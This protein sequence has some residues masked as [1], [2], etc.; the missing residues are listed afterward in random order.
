MCTLQKSP[1]LRKGKYAQPKGKAEVP[2]DLG[3]PQS[4][5]PGMVI[6][7][8]SKVPV[9][10]ATFYLYSPVWIPAPIAREHDGSSA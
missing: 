2:N 4:S 5:D 3:P 9:T 6:A 10:P 1:P 7:F 8:D